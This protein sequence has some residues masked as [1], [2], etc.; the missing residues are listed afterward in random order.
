MNDL[1]SAVEVLVLSS[2]P[3][4]VSLFSSPDLE[5]AKIRFQSV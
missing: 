2:I 4:A 5:A 3:V 1:R